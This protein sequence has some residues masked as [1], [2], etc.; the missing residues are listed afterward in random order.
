MGSIPE[1][2]LPNGSTH[3]VD[4]VGQR[5]FVARHGLYTDEQSAAA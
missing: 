4:G 2:K 5:G 3:L 1:S